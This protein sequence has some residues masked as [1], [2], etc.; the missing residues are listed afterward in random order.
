MGHE[1]LKFKI[2]NKTAIITMN[3]PKYRNAFSL[4]MLESWVK[5]LD[6]CKGD[7]DVSVIIL[8]GEGKSFSA[9]GDV[10]HFIRPDLK[11]WTMKN[12]LQEKVHQVA[13]A[14]KRLNKPLIAAV[15][16]PAYG[17][18][19]D[20]SLLCDMRIASDRA[21]F[22]E[23]YIKLG[24]APGDGGAYLLPRVVGTS[25]ALEWLLTGDIIDAE[26]ALRFGLVN[27]VVPHHNLMETTLNLAK[28]I[29]D[30]SPAAVRITK[31]A[32][33]QSLFSNL[34]DHLDYIS[35]QMGLL[36]ETDYYKDAVE[37]FHQKVSQKA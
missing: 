32:V 4:E 18:G 5:A 21:S 15:N 30:H 37:A 6:I 23:S 14:V 28:K 13:H 8:T 2:E 11:A 16:G 22:C 31:R 34:D 26:E 27:M 29:G 35:S 1:D 10:K 25:K 12:F 20:M 3:R 7:P 19:M 9:G 24:L 36:C 33:Y 17:A